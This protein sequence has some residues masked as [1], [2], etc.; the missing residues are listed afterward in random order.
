M[1]FIM[2]N[3]LLL[4]MNSAQAKKHP[5]LQ[6]KRVTIAVIAVFSKDILKTTPIKYS[7]FPPS[8]VLPCVTCSPGL[9]F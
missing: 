6:G 3:D 7:H 2:Y 4:T 8:S 9:K 1:L 5:K